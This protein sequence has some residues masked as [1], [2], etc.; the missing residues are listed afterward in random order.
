MTRSG[1][2]CIYIYMTTPLDD[3][4]MRAISTDC[5][6]FNLRR[7]T[8]A[9][10]QLYDQTLAGTGLR[11]TQVTLLVAVERAKGAPAG[12][13][14]E[15]L[16]M[17]KT[18]LSR[19]LAPLRRAKLVELRAGDD[20]RTRSL[21][22]TAKGI[23]ALARAVPLWQKAQRSVIQQVGGEGWATLRRDLERLTTLTMDGIV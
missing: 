22:L 16:G 11:V 23:A 5:V 9:I 17:D 6:C 2:S 19:N 10:T 18:T 12:K 14:A 15:F 1:N 13:L 3:A 4:T 20:R 7:T 8:R 21:A